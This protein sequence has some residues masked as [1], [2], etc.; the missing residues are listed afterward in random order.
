[1]FFAS[2]FN[3]LIFA[4]AFFERFSAALPM[5]LMHP[6]LT[7]LLLTPYI[8]EEP[9][10]YAEAYTGGIMLLAALFIYLSAVEQ[11]GSQYL[12]ASPL[13][14]LRAFLRAWSSGDP[15]KI[16]SLIEEVSIPETVITGLASFSRGENPLILVIPGVHPGPLYPVGSWNLPYQLFEY[17][18][19]RR[20][21]PLVF[22]GISNHEVNLPSKEAVRH[23][24]SSMEDATTVS[25]SSKCSKSLRVSQ[26]RAIASGICFGDTTLL[27]ATLS[28]HGMEDFPLTVRQKIS[29]YASSL[30]F[31]EVFIIDAHN[32]LGSVST[33]KDCAEVVDAACRLLVELKKAPQYPFK[34]GYAHSSETS[35]SFGGDMGPGG[36]GMAVIEVEGERFVTIAADANNATSGL[37]ERIME[38][39]KGSP[40]SIMEICTSD[41]HFSAGRIMNTEGYSPLGEETPFEKLIGAFDSLIQ[42]AS[43]DTHPSTFTASIVKSKVRVFGSRALDNFSKALDRVTFTAKWGGLVIIFISIAILFIVVT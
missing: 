14:Y 26:G 43:G 23:Y 21:A 32:S 42:K 22:H 10:R 30:G 6:F 39:Y 19:N 24:L 31:K 41:T 11:S 25:S 17:F 38:H 9:L 27:A 4:S 40:A 1:M 8:L 7:G 33:E 15:D 3:F 34:I 2:A 13:K 16:E 29:S 20:Y 18:S 28:P 35:L 12:A 5:S 36:V 37:R